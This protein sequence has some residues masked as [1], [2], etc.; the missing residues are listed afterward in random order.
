MKRFLLPLLAALAFPTAVNAGVDPEVHNLCKDVSDYMGCVK[1]NSKKEG[2]NLFKKDKNKILKLT[3]EQKIEWCNYGDHSEEYMKLVNN[4]I[5]NLESLGPKAMNNLSMEINER[6]SS[7]DNFDTYLGC[8]S[9]LGQ[10]ISNFNK[11]ESALIKKKR[12]EIRAKNL[13]EAGAP[14]LEEEIRANNPGM[15]LGDIAK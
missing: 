3:K 6:C 1:A 8:L 7:T 15:K 12:E 2:W 14:S 13:R 11:V 5:A 10:D 4:C 9:Y